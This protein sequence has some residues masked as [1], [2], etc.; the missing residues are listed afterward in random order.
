ML[1]TNNSQ[2]EQENDMG[3][4]YEEEMWSQ[5]QIKELIE[6]TQWLREE[7]ETL[8]AMVIASDAMIR[9]K[10]AQLKAQTYTQIINNDERN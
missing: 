1:K 7:N 2:L 4:P 9:N 10:E 6:Y 8:K 5:T 3:S